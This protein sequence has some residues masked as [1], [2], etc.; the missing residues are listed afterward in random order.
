MEPWLA[1]LYLILRAIALALVP[2]LLLAW[3]WWGSDASFL[4]SLSYVTQIAVLFLFVFLPRRA[5][6]SQ[7]ARTLIQLLC[8]IAAILVIPSI[9]SALTLPGGPDTMAIVIRLAVCGL[10][11]ATIIE[12]RIWSPHS[13]AV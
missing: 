6:L 1:P 3:G 12:A 11:A 13:S 5:Y 10:F 2:V 8:V 9:W 7:K 4:S